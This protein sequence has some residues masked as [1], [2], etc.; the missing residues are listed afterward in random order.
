MPQNENPYSAFSYEMQSV[1]NTINGA[2]QSFQLRL[3]KLIT[4]L[5]GSVLK[6]GR[7]LVDFIQYLAN[8]DD[9]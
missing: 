1:Y 5:T 4:Q 7:I 8:I 9:N 6:F 3:Q 2:L